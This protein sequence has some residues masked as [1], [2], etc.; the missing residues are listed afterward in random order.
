MQYLK[1]LISKR[2][3]P[4]LIGA[5]IF[6]WIIFFQINLREFYQ[7]I[8]QINGRYLILI[9]ILF[10]FST[11]IP[12]WRWQYCFKK[13]GPKL[14][15]SVAYY[16]TSTSFL[17]GLITPARIGEIGSRV[18]FFLDD[19]KK[20]NKALTAATLERLADIAFLIALT[21]FSLFFFADLLPKNILIV[22][23]ATLVGI[24]LLILLNIKGGLNRF[25]KK[26][27]TWIVPRRFKKVH[28]HFENFFENIQT[29]SFSAFLGIALL[30]ALLWLLAILTTYLFAKSLGVKIN[31]FYFAMASAV[32]SLM[33]VLPI[34][35]SG[36]GTREAAYLLLLTP[37]SISSE[38]IVAFSLGSNL[39]FILLLALTGLI[40][41][42]FKPK[43]IAI[44]ISNNKNYHE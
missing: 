13:L 39:L 25:S 43:N 23:W 30:T 31:F 7:T 41:L 8:K 37:L 16:I 1:N 11:I 17:F 18:S 22:A 20:L 29:I 15:F 36:L 9:F 26:I 40:C 2:N 34:S 10:I 38:K 24:L 5:V 21:G 33:S 6:L 14:T 4:K 12:A 44:I 3:L 28:F 42:F 35:I 19:P 27:F 32:A